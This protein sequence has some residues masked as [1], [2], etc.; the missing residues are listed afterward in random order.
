MF[1]FKCVSGHKVMAD[2]CMWVSVA[3]LTVCLEV[4]FKKKSTVPAKN[5][6]QCYDGS[7]IYVCDSQIHSRCILPTGWKSSTGGQCYTS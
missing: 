7:S 3:C 5:A 6:L 1:H 4:P 2:Q